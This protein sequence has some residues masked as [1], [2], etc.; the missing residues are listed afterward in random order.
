[1]SLVDIV[2]KVLQEIEVRGIDLSGLGD[3]AA[4]E[5]AEAIAAKTYASGTEP[6]V[7]EVNANWAFLLR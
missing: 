6:L 7:E 4:D 5:I 2:A 1:M 3:E